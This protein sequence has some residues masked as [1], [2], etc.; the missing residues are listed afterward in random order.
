MKKVIY[1]DF[2]G[3]LVDTPRLINAE[4]KIKG[5]TDKTCQNFSWKYFLKNCHEIE[6]NFTYIKELS[7]KFEIIILTHVYSTNEQIEKQK[8]ISE[9]LNDIKV[10]P[11]PYYIDK[12]VIVNPRGNI[13]IDDYHINIDKWNKSGGIGIYFNNEKRIDILIND[14]LKK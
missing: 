9:K 5:N 11:V 6:N 12:N 13:L 1:V 7:K 8:F 10:I 4:I 3:V 2:D 14:Y